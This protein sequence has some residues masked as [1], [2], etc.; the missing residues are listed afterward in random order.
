MKE[1]KPTY[2]E[3]EQR[4]AELEA[5]RGELQ[6]D[7]LIQNSYFTALIDATDNICV[8][9]DLNLRVIAANHAFA[10]VAGKNS[11]DELIG[12]TDAEIFGIS[13]NSS[14]V[15]GYMDDEFAAQR[16]KK[17]ERILREERIV[18]P[19]KSMGTILTTKFPVYGNEG[20]VIATASISVDITE[21]VKVQQK[22]KESHE[23]FR[24]LNMKLTEMLHISNLRDI[25]QT[26]TR[27]LQQQ[28]SDTLV[29]YL[30]IDEEKNTIVLES[31]SGLE[32]KLLKRMLDMLGYNAIGKEF[33][34]L[35]KMKAFFKEARFVEVGSLAELSTSEFPATI[36]KTI[37]RI[38]GIHKIYTVGITEDE[39]LL[40]TIHLFTFNKKEIQDRNFIEIFVK[41]VGIIVKNKMSEIELLKSEKAL[42]DLNKTKDKLFSIIAH[43]LRNPLNNMIGFSELIKKN[44]DRYP[45]EKIKKFIDL[46]YSS[47]QNVSVLLENLLTWSRTQQNNIEFN[48]EN[49]NM[50]VSVEQCFELM[51]L[52]AKKKQIVLKNELETNLAVHAD[53]EMLNTVLRNLL[54]N[55]IKY[56]PVGG[57]IEVGANQT[58]GFITT[59]VQDS[60]IG[61]EPEDLKKLFGIRKAPSMTGTAGEK[62]SGLGLVITKEF[63]GMNKGNIWVE[64]E[65]E[66]GTTFYFSLP[67]AK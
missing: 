66:Q 41:G 27:S 59:Y 1:G 65:P 43:D 42:L 6:N 18:Y 5:E 54:S 51:D 19:D 12:K 60:G 37:E 4:V 35:P 67:V 48:P 14:P 8:V 9:K 28:Y 34:L 16:L 31:L 36:A 55:A 57:T 29:L 53:K 22:L 17:G 56:T 13:Q 21:R 47:S 2:E 63:I 44:Y 3:L 33:K 49:I 46:I 10:K 7:D 61:I 62:G 25:Y 39:K 45:D 23:S 58:N 11:P 32:D 20:H 52:S 26:A 30:S 38:L 64:S 15:K 24:L 40:A 50:Y